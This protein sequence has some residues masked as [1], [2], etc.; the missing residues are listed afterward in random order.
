MNVNTYISS[1][2]MQVVKRSG[3]QTISRKLHE[4]SNCKHHQILSKRDGRNL[5]YSCDV[6]AKYL[7]ATKYRRHV[8]DG[9]S[10]VRSKRW[11]IATHF[12]IKNHTSCQ[13][14]AN[15][16][17][18]TVG[19]LTLACQLRRSTN[20]VNHVPTLDQRLVADWEGQNQALGT[21]H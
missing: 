9:W 14:W 5:R 6:T 4:V 12:T 11:L 3:A 18:P 15:H 10:M 20:H 21:D 19:L 7:C 17:N 2:S 1:S 8:A 13:H 16:I